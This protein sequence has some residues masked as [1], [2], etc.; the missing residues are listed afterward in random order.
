MERLKLVQGLSYS[1]GDIVATKAHP[2]S[3][4]S[5]TDRI[6]RSHRFRFFFRE[7]GACP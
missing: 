3:E 4:L 1:Y 5:G 6:L 2:G 7:G